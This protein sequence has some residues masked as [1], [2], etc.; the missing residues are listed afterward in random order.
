MSNGRLSMSVT[1]T[2][3]FNSRGASSGQRYADMMNT[4]TGEL[5]WVPDSYTAL[6]VFVSTPTLSDG[7]FGAGWSYNGTSGRVIMPVPASMTRSVLTHEFG[8][9]LGLMHANSLEC[10]SGAQDVATNPDGSF[11]DST[12][13]I[14]EYGDTLDLMGAS[15]PDQP[16]ISSTLWDFGG[17]GTGHD[18]LNVGKPDAASSYTLTAWAGKADNRALKFTDP[19]SGEAY[20]LELRLPVG[21]DA[22]YAVNGNRGV[23]IVQQFGAGSLI[24]MP[25][26]RHFAGYYSARH[27]WQAGQTFTTHAGTRVTINWIS[28]SAAGVTI[29]S[30]PATALR[31][32]AAVAASSSAGLGAQTS[33]VV[34]GLRDGGCFQGFQNGAAMWSP[35]SGAQPSLFGPV[36]DA[37]QRSGF[38]NGAMGYPVSGLICG[39]K[40]DGCFQNYQG[41]SIMWSPSSGA[42]LSTFGAIRDFWQ[43]Q[44]FE[45]GPLGYPVSD[46][47]CGLKNGGCFQNFQGGTVMWSPATGAQTI[48]PGPVQQVWQGSGYEGGTLGYPTGKQECNTRTTECTQTFQSG[49]AAWSNINGGWTVPGATT[50]A[51]RPAEV[52]YPVSAQVC[53]LR[54]GGCF[55]NFQQGVIMYA[56]ASGAFP[57]SGA[58]LH[59][60][61]QSGF[62]NGSLGYP[63]SGQNCQLK[64]DGCFQNFEKASVLSSP[65]TGTHPVYA[66]PFLI[67]WAGTGYEN[68]ALG[69]P[70]SHP[71][72]G[73]RNGGCFQNFEGGTIMWSP[74]T[75]A[76]PIT[77]APVRAAWGRSGFENGSLG[78]PTNSIVCGLKNG[79][80]FQNFEKGSIM[81]SPLTGAA[82]V[83]LGPIQA[84]WGQQGFENGRLGYPT[85]TQ[86]CTADTTS[87]TQTFQAGKITWTATDGAR[88]Q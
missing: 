2:E 66:G 12:C 10:G 44:N 38:E 72:C 34:C 49:T 14:R 64:N 76:Q 27:T 43:Q 17:F 78:Y 24:L 69:Y 85:G 46:A 18:I 41:G 22:S 52:G 35:A 28:D 80:C 55:Q 20:Y 3:T 79:G 6:V 26:S 74:A 71:S 51:W 58:T 32:I 16:V 23:K 31:A 13:S 37:W 42:A 84:A 7:A 63:V 39:L 67:T 62:E 30:T 54:A 87:C 86:T 33:G 19:V 59:D 68:G 9:V 53:G 73:L 70:A 82:P 21:Y 47:Y 75:G 48:V 45:N 60:W 1:S 57:L 50:A 25:D 81:W 11:A 4:I 40:N 15:H 77:S 56:P 83:I 8:H 29:E 36:R 88:I 61:Q 5:G 65:A